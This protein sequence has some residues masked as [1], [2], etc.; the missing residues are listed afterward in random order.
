MIFSFIK[1]DIINLQTVPMNFA[2]ILRVSGKLD[3]EVSYCNLDQQGDWEVFIVRIYYVNREPV[4]SQN[5]IEEEEH[6][7]LH[8]CKLYLDYLYR[9]IFRNTLPLYII[10]RISLGPFV[11]TDY[12]VPIF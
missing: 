12:E 3:S 4:D 2:T 5:P 9:E 11:Y 1:G 8:L 10:A 6:T 7:G